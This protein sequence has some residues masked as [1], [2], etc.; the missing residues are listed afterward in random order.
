MI[1]RTG[2]LTRG[3]FTWRYEIDSDL[4][5]STALVRHLFDGFED[6][7]LFSREFVDDDQLVPL[8]RCEHKRPDDATHCYVARRNLGDAKAARAKRLSAALP[9]PDGAHHMRHC[10]CYWPAANGGACPRCGEIGE[11]FAP[12]V[13]LKNSRD[14]SMTHVETTEVSVLRALID[15][16]HDHRDSRMFTEVMGCVTWRGENG[17]DGLAERLTA[18]GYRVV[19][20]PATRRAK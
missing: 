19:R 15:A 17:I 20:Q 7:P 12:E 13:T 11:V 16:G 2:T 3:R 5:E 9:A 1:A 14:K 10:G 18:K 4:P 6:E 8:C